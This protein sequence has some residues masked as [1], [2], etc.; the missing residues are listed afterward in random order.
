MLRFELKCVGFIYFFLGEA[1][2][3]LGE[4]SPMPPRPGGEVPNAPKALG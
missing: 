1:P 3:V 2:Q 4:G